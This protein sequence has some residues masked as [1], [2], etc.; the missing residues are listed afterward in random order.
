MA[1]NG[2]IVSV[3]IRWITV[4][5]YV[6][7]WQPFAVQFKNNEPVV[8]QKK[9]KEFVAAIVDVLIDPLNKVTICNGMII[10]GC[11]RWAAC[12]EALNKGLIDPEFSFPVVF[13]VR[14]ETYSETC[15][16]AYRSNFQQNTNSRNHAV[17]G[18]MNVSK[19]LIAPMMDAVNT[20]CPKY[21]K[22]RSMALKL[23][24]RLA[25]IFFR[26]PGLQQQLLATS[27]GGA[28]MTIDAVDLYDSRRDALASARFVEVNKNVTKAHDL[29][30][31]VRPLAG[32]L[33]PSLQLIQ[34]MRDSGEWSRYHLNTSMEYI[35]IE[36]GLR[37]LLA[38]PKAVELLEKRI[39][40]HAGKLHDHMDAFAHN[41]KHS[42]DM[43]L[44][45]LKPAEFTLPRLPRA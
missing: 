4:R 29:R 13:E 17:G 28:A 16:R 21:K 45:K 9:V 38:R 24:Q 23:A 33:N 36:F 30:P 32:L 11:H 18:G 44:R 43:I 42:R 39:K 10:Q 3:N 25:A 14:N 15:E 26:S 41:P 22:G 20:A 19:Y 8:Q 31:L 34:S 27:N 1:K 6:N 37:G 40:A 2:V 7:N 5:E 12:I 35:I